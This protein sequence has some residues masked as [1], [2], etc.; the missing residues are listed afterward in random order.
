MADL[1]VEVLL[2]CAL[3]AC[4]LVDTA[5]GVLV[6][7]DSVFVNKLGIFR[8]NEEIII[9]GVMFAGFGAIVAKSAD[10]FES[11]QVSEAFGGIIEYFAGAA[12][13]L[14]IEVIGMVLAFVL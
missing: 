1:A 5:A 6:Q 13:N 9:L 14:G 10:V 4:Y 2:L 7:R 3:P 12:A 8:L 11:H